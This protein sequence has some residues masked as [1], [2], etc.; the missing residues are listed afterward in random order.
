MARGLIDMKRMSVKEFRELGFLQEVNRQFLH[1]LGLALE[2]IIEEG[3]S[4]RFGEVWDNSDDPGGITFLN[5]SHDKSLSVQDWKGE[6]KEIREDML[7]FYIQP[8]ED[9][10]HVA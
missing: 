6:R 4:V 7:G 9:C 5:I 1:P 2:V 3:G 8:V 10:D